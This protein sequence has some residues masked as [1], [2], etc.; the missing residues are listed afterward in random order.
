[1]TEQEI[2]APLYTPASSGAKAW[3]GGPIP[4]GPC[5]AVAGGRAGG[6]LGTAPRSSSSNAPNPKK[7]SGP[8]P[9]LPL[10][11]SLNALLA[12]IK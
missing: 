4:E 11:G 6:R 9:L 7:L 2:I 10:T 12:W 1:M 3:L 5:S 8:H